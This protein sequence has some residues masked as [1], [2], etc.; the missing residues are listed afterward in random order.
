MRTFGQ[1]DVLVNVAYKPSVHS[2]LLDS[3]S[4][5]AEWRAHFDTNLFGTLQMTKAVAHHMAAR[6]SGTIVMVN[7][8]AAE[9][10]SK[11]LGGYT[12]SKAALERIVRTLALELAERGVRVNG[13]HPGYMWGSWMEEVMRRRALANGTDPETEKAAVEAEIPLGYIPPTREFVGTILYL[14]SDLSRPTTGQAIHVNGGHW[15]H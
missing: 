15:F 3:S 14:A 13:V 5:L 8:M 7:S 12:G 9:R 4:D 11:G 2:P 6:G 1:I 10:V